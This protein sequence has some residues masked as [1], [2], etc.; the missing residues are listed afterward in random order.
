L[1][2]PDLSSKTQ[3][4]IRGDAKKKKGK[5]SNEVNKV[6]TEKDAGVTYV[7]PV[8]SLSRKRSSPGAQVS[9]TYVIL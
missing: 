1:Q 9:V 3:V 2:T 7:E 4:L 6:R 8:A 5:Q